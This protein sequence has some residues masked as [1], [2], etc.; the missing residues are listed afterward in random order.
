MKL[1]LTPKTDSAPAG[2]ASGAIAMERNGGDFVAPITL[3][4]R[5]ATGSM[6]AVASQSRIKLTS[7]CESTKN[8][9]RRALIRTSVPYI[10]LFP[11]NSQDGSSVSTVSAARS[12]KEISFH[13]VMTVPRECFDDIVNQKAGSEGYKLAVTQIIAA[14]KLHLVAIGDGTGKVQETSGSA[15]STLALTSA[16][17]YAGVKFDPVANVLSEEDVYAHLRTPAADDIRAF[18]PNVADQPWLRALT[19]LKPIADDAEIGIEVNVKE[20]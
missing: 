8:G 3:Q 1:K 2:T 19:G 12:G 13:T 16:S 14:L 5:P 20:G 4:L 18:P 10:G 6:P 17:R 9:T 15:G 11:A 7:A